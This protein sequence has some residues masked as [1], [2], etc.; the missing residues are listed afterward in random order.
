MVTDEDIQILEQ[1]NMEILAQWWCDLNH[2]AWPEQ[3]PNPESE[4]KWKPDSRRNELMEWIMD[5]VGQRVISRTWNKDMSNE[6]FND[7]FRGTYEGHA[8]SLKRHRARR[9]KRLL[10]TS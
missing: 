5:R 9:D 6:E 3:L 7:F 2:W 1:Q 10:S 4:K 8:A